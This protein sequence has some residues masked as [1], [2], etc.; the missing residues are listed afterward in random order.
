MPHLHALIAEQV[1]AWKKAD[2]SCEEFPVISEILE[3]QITHSE[4]DAPVESRYLRSAQIEALTL[5][6]KMK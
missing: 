3:Y 1:A 6:R 5:K 4:K 2:Y